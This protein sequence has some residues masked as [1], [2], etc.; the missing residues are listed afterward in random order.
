[1]TIR[2]HSDGCDKAVD[3]KL[4]R[5]DAGVQEWDHDGARHALGPEECAL[6]LAERA[7][8]LERGQDRLR[9]SLEDLPTE[10]VPEVDGR[11]QTSG[12]AETGTTA[13]HRRDSA[14]LAHREPHDLDPWEAP[15]AVRRP[16][17]GGGRWRAPFSNAGP[18]WPNALAVLDL[19]LL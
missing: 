2:D 1:L 3:P 10:A 16:A 9:A 11:R 4:A 12:A 8:I 19:K 17:K 5:T 6:G 7:L 18:P 13:D 15:E 14:G